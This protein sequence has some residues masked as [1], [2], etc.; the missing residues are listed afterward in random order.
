MS[1][2]AKMA[3]QMLAYSL[4]ITTIHRFQG[5]RGTVCMASID[6]MI[7]YVYYI[8]HLTPELI[9]TLKLGVAHHCDIDSKPVIYNHI[10]GCLMVYLYVVN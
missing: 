3:G 9:D 2:V 6:L 5:Y 7:T 4:P 10:E 8:I 1:D